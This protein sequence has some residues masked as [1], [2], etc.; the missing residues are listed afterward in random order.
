MEPQWELP[1]DHFYHVKDTTCVITVLCTHFGYGFAFPDCSA[2]PMTT[3]HGLQDTLFTIMI[4]TQDGFWPE[5]N[6]TLHQMR[7]V[8]RV[9]F[10]KLTFLT[11]FFLITWNQNLTEWCVV[12]WSFPKTPVFHGP[13]NIL[14]DV[15]YF[16]I[17]RYYACYLL[18][19][20]LRSEKE[21]WIREWLFSYSW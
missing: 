8:S 18:T 19:R 4:F 1:L 9:M 5:N 16:Q 20:I 21:G 2:S 13:D 11:I 14:Q 10:I 7:C 15:L 17:S 12:G 6:F 3:I